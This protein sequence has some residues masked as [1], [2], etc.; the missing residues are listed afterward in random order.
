M[1]ISEGILNAPVL[2]GCGVAA[3]ACTAVGLK[4]LDIDRIMNVSL[5]TSTFFIASLIHVPLGPG[6]IHLVLNGLLG[7]ILGWVSFPAI[8]TALLLQAL[9]FQYGGFTVLGVNT[10][11]M[12]L[13]A[14]LAFYIVRPWL[15]D[16]DKKRS[17]AAF[18]AGFLAIF[19]S[20]ILMA[21][22][23]I[24]SDS[25]FFDTAVLILAAQ[26]PLMIIEG[27]ITMFAVLFLAKVQPDFLYNNKS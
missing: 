11:I 10:I 3:A 24:T 7:V 1:H 27:F 12:A 4:K 25:G 18:A 20:S 5:L 21:L 6:S 8:V 14:L 13:P 17:V 23:L 16:N 26:L 19:S 22:A 15:K 9:F 2:I